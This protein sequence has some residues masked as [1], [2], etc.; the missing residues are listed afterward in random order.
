[1]VR[2]F[3]PGVLKSALELAVCA[4]MFLSGLRRSEIFALKPEDLDWHSPKITVRRAWQNFDRKDRV[5]GPP[6]GKRERDAPFDPVL[7]EAV[8]K[9]WAENGRHEFVFSYKNGTTPGP[10]W[11]RGRFSKWLVRAGIPLE[12]RN[13]V[14]HSS[15]H[16]LASLLEERGV[17][18]RYIQELLGH[19]DLETTK[20]YLHSTGATLRNIGQKISKAME[21]EDR[22]TV[23]FRVS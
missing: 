1:M 7:Q 15:R 16:S 13:I 19:S 18:L 23:S 10:S 17:S 12:G 11:I 5:L 4:A 8:R 20:G 6:K 3:E 2:L 14:P 22:N 21:K 9:L